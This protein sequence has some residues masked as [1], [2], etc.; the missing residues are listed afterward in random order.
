LRLEGGRLAEDGVEVFERA[1]LR[2]RDGELHPSGSIDPEG[3]ALGPDRTLYLSSEGIARR[4]IAPFVARLDERGREVAQ[5]PL[6]RRYIPD[7]VAARGVRDNLGFESLTVPPGGKWLIAALENALA[8]DGPAADFGVG[9]PARVIFWPLAGGDVREHVYEVEPLE[10]ALP[11]PHAYRVRGLVD[12]LA[13]SDERFLALEREY[14]AGVGQR[15]ELFL[16]EVG[17]A[18]DIVGLDSLEGASYRPLAKRRLLDFAEIGLPLDNFEGLALGPILPDGRRLLVA[19]SDD[20]FDALRQR[21]LF[22]AFAVG[23]EPL[24]IARVQGP[25]HRSP[26]EGRWVDG[27]EG[28]VT[29]VERRPGTRG[30]FFESSVPDGD[31]RTSEGLR[32]AWEEVDELLPGDRVR[33]TGRVEERA[34]DDRQLPVTTLR[35][36]GLE[37][38]ERD[39]QLPP[40]AR[41]GIDFRVPERIAEGAL[42]ELAPERR[43]ID[44]WE[45][46]EGMRVELPGGVVTGATRAFGELVL[47]PEG[48]AP[49]APR[50]D[51][52]GLRLAPEGPALERAILSRRLVG[53]IPELAV[54]ARVAGP[55]VGVVDYSFSNYKVLPLAALDVGGEGA[56]CTL[57]QP[58]VF[59]ARGL[60]VA[61]FNVENLSVA[62]AAS[63]FAELARIVVGALGA[64]AILGLQEVQDDSGNVAGDGVVTAERTLAA[65][66]GAIRDAGGPA[67]EPIVVDPE[68]GREGGVPGG[69]IRVALLFDPTRLRFDRRGQAGP[70]T[71]GRLARDAHGDFRLEPNPARVDPAS[72]AFTLAD[73]EGVRRSLVVELE[74]TG[75]PLLVIVN[76]WSSK[77]EDD[78]A[79]GARQPPRQPTGERR[80]TQARVIR[81]F[82]ERALALAP[83]ARILI[84]GDLNDVPWSEPVR[85]LSAPPL[86]D[87][88][89]LLAESDRYSYNF[90]GSAQLI[91]Y[92]LASPALAAD[93]RIAIPHVASNCPDA[94]RASDHDPVVARFPKPERLP[95][96]E[97]AVRRRRA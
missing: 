57:P 47:L 67:Y 81:A 94:V 5:L 90:E 97:R 72:P 37:R 18:T 62:G 49:A 61:T 2:D 92:I 33:A 50:T 60:D 71:A 78:R 29:A 35:V 14:V 3:W 43:A 89:T 64:P 7:E 46:L 12:L 84:L 63:R 36:T 88:T 77:F 69:N 82:V 34:A 30:F 79:F 55:I 39:A 44:L 59:A 22:W 83:E 48:G 26:Y 1:H 41:W 27:I 10:S 75:R 4:G 15:V 23:F 58:G 31:P 56:G 51:A 53:S 21:T 13:L 38:R 74:E 32:A 95:R 65:L 25:A 86:L 66:V 20:N 68:I 24:D 17:E 70:L 54:G 8:Q 19:V 93:A 45:S 40:A 16:A 28:V 73:G 9:S 6:P 80:L 42:G 85:T 11:T 87:L 52:G 76:H 91:D 96:A